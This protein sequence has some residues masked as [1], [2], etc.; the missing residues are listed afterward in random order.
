MSCTWYWKI[1]IEAQILHYYI[2]IGNPL[3]LYGLQG[4]ITQISKQKECIKVKMGYGSIY[5]AWISS[6]QAKTIEA[7]YLK[8]TSWAWANFIKHW[9][10]SISSKMESIQGGTLNHTNNN[11]ILQRLISL[12]IQYHFHNQIVEFHQNLLKIIQGFKRLIHHIVTY[13]II[14]ALLLSKI[15]SRVLNSNCLMKEVLKCV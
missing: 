1:H 13:L 7:K 11:T 10:T 5:I 12:Q 9:T 3:H 14:I 4:L 15:L 6:W 8:C 2:E